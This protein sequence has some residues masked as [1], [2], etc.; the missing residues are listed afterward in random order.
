[1]I[2]YYQH[3]NTQECF[4]TWQRHK[5]RNFN[6]DMQWHLPKSCQDSG[7]SRLH[8]VRMK[9]LPR[10]VGR[11]WGHGLNPASPT[12]AVLLSRTLGWGKG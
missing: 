4:E 1:M 11:S 10:W 2:W 7:I 6:Y 9:I 12:G 8:N 5:D 3:N